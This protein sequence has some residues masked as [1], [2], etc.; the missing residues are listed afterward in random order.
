MK[1]TDYGRMLRLCQ[2]DTVYHEWFASH[3]GGFKP[4]APDSLW[5]TLSE[6]EYRD[7]CMA[8]KKKNPA[9]TNHLVSVRNHSRDK[10]VRY[11]TA[12][13]RDLPPESPAAVKT[14]AA[15]EAG[16]ESP[17]PTTWWYHPES[18]CVLCAA[19][20][21]SLLSLTHPSSATAV[22][23]QID[24]DQ[25]REAVANGA[26]I[27]KEVEHLLRVTAEEFAADCALFDDDLD[28]LGLGDDDEDLGL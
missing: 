23:D 26:S 1:A 16:D 21:E 10:L 17:V 2:N 13:L 19:D 7:Y 28:D 24:I 14:W 25:A 15:I 18:D 4:V 6:Q 5:W 9:H 22:C 20:P 11:Y 12:Y 27:D 3:G 8:G